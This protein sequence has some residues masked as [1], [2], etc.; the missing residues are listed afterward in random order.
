MRRGLLGVGVAGLALV[1]AFFLPREDPV[2]TAGEFLRGYTPQG[3]PD[4]QWPKAPSGARVA[5]QNAVYRRSSAGA[6]PEISRATA[7]FVSRGW[8][9]VP[10]STG[11]H[12][13]FVHETEP[14]LDKWLARLRLSARV[15]RRRAIAVEISNLPVTG[16]MSHAEWFRRG[17]RTDAATSVHVWTLDYPLPKIP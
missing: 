14:L 11:T 13:F 6:A 4:L 3:E 5:Y 8:R 7:L 15:G 9:L 2:G 1:A 16:G 10:G 17:R 12:A